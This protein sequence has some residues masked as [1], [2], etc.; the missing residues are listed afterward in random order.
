[1]T[2]HVL[3]LLQDN[4]T[5]GEILEFQFTGLVV[6]FGALAS[7][8]VFLELMGMFFR[9]QAARNPGPTTQPKFSGEPLKPPPEKLPPELVAVLAASVQV[10]LKGRRHRVVSITQT[11]STSNWAA[12]GRREHFSSHRVR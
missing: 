7:L 2:M 1:M 10:A 3:A 11:T 8:W 4:P 12:E 9:H 6:V 5:T